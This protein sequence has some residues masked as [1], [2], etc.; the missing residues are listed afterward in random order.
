[1]STRSD[2]LSFSNISFERIFHIDFDRNVQALDNSNLNLL[3][4]YPKA[5]GNAQNDAL[6]KINDWGY[7]NKTKFNRAK[8][9]VTIFLN[10]DLI[11]KIA[12]QWKTCDNQKVD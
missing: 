4:P 9:K 5:L 6:V 8:I 3:F 12:I 7:E 10:R 11:C 1:M 2:S